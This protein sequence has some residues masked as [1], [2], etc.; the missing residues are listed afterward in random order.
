VRYILLDVAHLHLV[1][2]LPLRAQAG[3]LGWVNQTVQDHIA[4]RFG[5]TVR[6]GQAKAIARPGDQGTSPLERS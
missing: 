3:H 1:R 6:H 5:Q 4:A 2:V